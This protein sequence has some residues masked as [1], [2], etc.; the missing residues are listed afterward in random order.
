MLHVLDSMVEVMDTEMPA[1]IARWGG[2]QASWQANVQTLRNWINSRCVNLVDGMIDCY[3]L[4]GPYVLKLEVMPAQAGQIKLNSD[5]ITNF[6]AVRNVYG[7]IETILE[8]IPQGN[9]QFSHWTFN[10][11]VVTDP[12]QLL[13]LIDFT[14]HNDIVAH[15]VD[16][17]QT[18]NQ[19]VYYWH[20][21]NFELVNDTPVNA[22][23]ADYQLFPSANATMTYLGGDPNMDPVSN[24]GSSQNLQFGE[25][26]GKGVR[27]R[28]PSQ[29]RTVVFNLPTTDL[30]EIQFLYSVKRTNHGQLT[31]NISY[32]IDGTNFI[33]SGLSQS[34]FDISTEYQLIALDFSNISAVNDN[35]NFHIRISFEGNTEIANGNNRFDNISLTGKTIQDPGVSIEQHPDFEFFVFPNPSSSNFFVSAT[36]NILEFKIIDMLGKTVIHSKGMNTSEFE[37]FSKYF[38]PGVYI[39][40]LHSELGTAQTRLIKQ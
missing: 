8:A 7:G 32:S 4:T 39:L 21:N 37:I 35:P 10:N 12:N 27:V 3:D 31:Q 18:E 11:L 29:G 15:F 1:Q 34:T 25:E 40:E 17:T 24:D 28:N 13:Q 26:A 19:L 20:F 2:N 33:T 22:I 23:L 16:V 30:E 9:Y 36:Q 6:G 38:A 14:T 5:L